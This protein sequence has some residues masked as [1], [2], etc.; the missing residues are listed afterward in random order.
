MRGEFSVSSFQFSVGKDC[1]EM[2]T[3]ENGFCGNLVVSCCG[4]Q[5]RG[6]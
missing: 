5:T 2:G 6:P 1:G 3:L 4:S